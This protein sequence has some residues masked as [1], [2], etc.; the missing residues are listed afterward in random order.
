M[1][2]FRFFSPILLII[3]SFNLL[4]SQTIILP[5][6]I[7][8]YLSGNFGELR[9]GHFHAGIDFKTQGQIGIPVKAVKNGSVS[10]IYISPWG[11]GRA[12]YIS[13]PDGT[14]TVY[15]HLDHFVDKIES[16]ARDSQYIKESFTVNLRLN[17]SKML[18]KQGEIIAFS[19]NTGSSKGPHL[20]FEI[21][22][23]KGDTIM[24]PLSVYKKQI[25]DTRPPE[26]RGL[27][28]FPQP[29]KGLVNGKTSIQ[30]IP[31]VKNKKGTMALNKTIYA[32]GEIGIGVKAYDKMTGV[33]N[34]YG[35]Q[36]IILRMNDK[37]IFH[38]RIDR[39]A[40]N[41]SRYINSF[42]NW[43]EWINNHSFYMKSFIEPGNKL[44]IYQTSNNGIITIDEQKNYRF[45]YTVSDAYGNKTAF[46]FNITGKKQ[47]IPA[48]RP[49]GTLYSY[50]TDNFIST[51]GMSLNIPKGNLYKD[52]YIRTT[53]V[54][55]YTPFSPLYGLNPRIPLH[56]YCPLTLKIVNDTYPDKTKYGVVVVKNNRESWLGGKYEK[57]EM[58][59]SVRELGNYAIRIDT[60]A[61]Q[62]VPVSPDKWTSE[63]KIT[64]QIQDN[65]SGIDFWRGTLNKQ[66]VLFEYDPKKNALFC[67]YDPLRMQS[68]NQE[69]EL[70]VSD[71][72]ENK[73]IYKSQICF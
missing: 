38:S 33:N 64:F 61:P 36:E 66:F 5:M 22:N 18:V 58:H 60:V 10:R 6:D 53:L 62:V 56:S 15:G 13:H 43:E 71:A 65:L 34:I 54:N 4:Q 50:L 16:L 25:A 40:F 35:P 21:R 31:L 27:M 1:R 67:V 72:C 68:G 28:F 32:W 41:E 29:G 39:F 3:F 47:A 48:Y 46:T 24:N 44:S 7:P 63:K 51:H 45:E 49:G 26:I 37:T 17:P 23:S 73:T 69:L 59:V 52:L 2:V 12:L 70:I 57:G 20:H 11:F 42:I 8:P 55:N 14:M 19:G 30:G 9:G